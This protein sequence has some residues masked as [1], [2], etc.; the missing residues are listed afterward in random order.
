MLWLCRSAEPNTPGCR[1]LNSFPTAASISP[2]PETNLRKS[3]SPDQY[4]TAP[5][6]S[7]QSASLVESSLAAPLYAETKL[8]ATIPTTTM[9]ASAVAASGSNPIDGNATGEAGLMIAN[10]GDAAHNSAAIVSNG[11]QPCALQ[12]HHPLL[13]EGC[14]DEG[15]AGTL[16]G[17]AAQAESSCVLEVSS[18]KQGQKGD[19]PA[20]KQQLT[21]IQTASMQPCKGTLQTLDMYDETE[22]CR[23]RQASKAALRVLAIQ[24]QQLMWAAKSKG[25]QNKSVPAWICGSAGPHS[26]DRSCSCSCSLKCINSNM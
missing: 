1:V 25:G 26:A 8:V 11:N 20:P 12:C 13:H 19:S 6:T 21:A 3:N 10:L 14:N 2:D 22:M 15:A 23:H 5:S 16:L 24:E 7:Q 17:T 18:S 9:T 4:M